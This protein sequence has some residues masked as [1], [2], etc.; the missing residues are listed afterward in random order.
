[1][2]ANLLTKTQHEDDD[3]LNPPKDLLNNLIDHYQNRRFDDAESLSLKITQS[4]PKN[5]LAWN[6]LGAVL[7]A[8]GKWTEAVL[9][10]QRAVELSPGDAEAHTNL[11]VSLQELGRLEE[12]EGGALPRAGAGRAGAPRPER[13]HLETPEATLQIGAE[14]RAGRAGGRAGG[15]GGGRETKGDAWEFTHREGLQLPR[16]CSRR[17]PS[18]PASPSSRRE[19]SL[20]ARS[21]NQLWSTR[22]KPRTV[23]VPKTSTPR[24]PARGCT[25]TPCRF[26]GR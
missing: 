2:R 7:G 23:S 16:P 21:A 6:V 4:F 17:H 3:K 24:P 10:M 18:S 8:K 19:P 15:R 5:Q 26:P 12:A 25:A 11:A 13:Q 20:S 22:L 1:M 14:G 9:A